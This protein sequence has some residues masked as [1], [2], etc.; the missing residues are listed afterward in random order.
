MFDD[1]KILRMSQASAQQAAFRQSVIAQNVANANTP[2]YRARD[3]DPFNKTYENEV[4]FAQ[5]GS[6]RHS[7]AGHI[8]TTN[9]APIRT[10]T[11]ATDTMSPNGN[12]VSLEDEIM[13]SVDTKRQY[14]LSL[15]I[16]KNAMTILRTSIG[17][18]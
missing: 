15:T 11:P 8:D 14:D 1:L 3:V 16:Y 9:E 5:S 6:M 12:S 7:R 17:R 2:D 13:K 18:G 10:F 4:G